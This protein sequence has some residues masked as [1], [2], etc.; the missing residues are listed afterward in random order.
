MKINEEK[1][2]S[3]LS[4]YGS[5]SVA[6]SGGVDSVLLAKAASMAKLEKLL[7]V[8]IESEFSPSLENSFAKEWAATNN[9]PISVIKLK[10]LSSPEIK[11]NCPKRCYHCKLM[12]MGEVIKE[13]EKN[14]IEIVAD[15]T[16]LD[17]FSD[18]RPGLKATE[19]L[20]IKHPLSDAGF[21]KN[22]I[23]RLARKYNLPNWREP[24]SACL[25]SRIPYKTPLDS[26][27]LEKIDKAE[28]FLKELGIAKR[29]ARLSDNGHIRIETSPIY[30][31][32]VIQ[33]SKAI[34]EFFL[35]LGFSGASLDLRGYRTGSLNEK[36]KK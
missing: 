12:I 28:I 21:N 27:T 9:L 5:L 22:M 20:E 6:F 4:S 35:H 17:D 11:K 16:N 2:L 29:R 25:A 32:R 7:L 13:A 18:Y 14:C 30:F 26:E 24:A 8:H 19:E 34:D 23:R 10:P 33:N 15:G 3:I 31:K 36:I 1:L